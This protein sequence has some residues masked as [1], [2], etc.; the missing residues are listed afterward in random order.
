MAERL[1]SAAGEHAAV[2]NS[3]LLGSNVNFQDKYISAIRRL[4]FSTVHQRNPD[5][6]KD[7]LCIDERLQ[8]VSSSTIRL[9][10]P[11]PLL[12]RTE[13]TLRQKAAE[14]III[15]NVFNHKSCGALGLNL[16]ALGEGLDLDPDKAG[17]FFAKRVA[18]DVTT[19]Y[20]GKHEARYGGTLEIVHGPVDQHRGQIAVYDGRVHGLDVAHIEEFDPAYTISRG[21]VGPDAARE[22]T[23]LALGI[24]FGDHGLGRELT[25]NNPF[26]LVGIADNQK[27]IGRM[28]D[29]L[30]LIRMSRGIDAERIKVQVIAA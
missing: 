12:Q 20:E 2:N 26:Y 28:T 30:N 24:A 21:I 25:P 3:E 27:E 5:E 13:L 16:A 7:V 1:Q 9:P 11:V 4:G 23:G 8:P 14:G 15:G 6:P 22:Y 19:V 17:G 10:G 29:E 18:R